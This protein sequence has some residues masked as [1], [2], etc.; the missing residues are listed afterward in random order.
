ML[1]CSSGVKLTGADFFSKKLSQVLYTIALSTVQFK[2]MK[3]H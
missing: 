1:P 3:V 2:F